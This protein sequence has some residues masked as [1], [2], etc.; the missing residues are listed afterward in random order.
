MTAADKASL[1]GDFVKLN[2]GGTKQDITGGGGLNVQ[3]SLES[4]NRV[5]SK[6]FTTP[7]TYDLGGLD[8]V[9]NVTGDITTDGNLYGLR[10]L[11]K[12][13]ATTDG[14]KTNQQLIGVSYD[15][16]ILTSAPNLEQITAF[17]AVKIGNTTAPNLKFAYGYT[18]NYH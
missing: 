14:S 2:D 8:R 7:N 6:F 3:G 5:L 11:P 16:T 1:D 10:F 12:S 13:V 18:S 4:N 15:S 9:V 17:W